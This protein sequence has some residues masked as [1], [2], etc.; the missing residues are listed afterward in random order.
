MT[1]R[2]SDADRLL[3]ALDIDGTLLG[4]DGS[5]DESVIR[6]EIGRGHV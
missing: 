4:E 1:P 3:I 5:L 6:E 2:V